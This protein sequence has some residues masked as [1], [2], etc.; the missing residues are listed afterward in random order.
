MWDW[1]PQEKQEMLLIRDNAAEQLIQSGYI[2][3][4]MFNRT[5]LLLNNYRKNH[6]SN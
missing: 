6:K 3:K 4:K 2:S 1:N 5:K